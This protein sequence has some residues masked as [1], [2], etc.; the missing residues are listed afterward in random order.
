MR[1]IHNIATGL[2]TVGLGLAARDVRGAPTQ[3]A[4]ISQKGDFALIGNTLGHDCAPGTPAPTNGTVGLCGLN[5]NET[6][7][8]VFWRADAPLPGQAQANALITAAQARSAAVLTLPPGGQVTHAFLYWGATLAAPGTDMKIT[9]DRE[10]GFTTTVDATKCYQS[11]SNS[12][13]CLAD[14]TSIV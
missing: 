10:G 2:L 6:S 3:R 9:L 8:D 13:Q 11:I 7:P 12:Y 5:I 14:V 4:Q 1:R